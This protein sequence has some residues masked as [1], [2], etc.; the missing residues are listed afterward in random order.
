MATGHKGLIIEM[1]LFSLLKKQGLILLQP[2]IQSTA[3]G[4]E[5][6]RQFWRT[7]ISVSYFHT[8]ML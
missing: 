4:K 7:A 2:R 3:E 8:T 6:T 1:F 5:S